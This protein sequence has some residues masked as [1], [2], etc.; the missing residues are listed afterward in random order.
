MNLRYAGRAALASGILAA[1]ALGS[2]GIGNLSLLSDTGN[3]TLG[4]PIRLALSGPGGAIYSLSMGLPGGAILPGVGPVD[5]DLAFFAVVANGP[6][7]SNGDLTF[8]YFVPLQPL[9]VGQEFVFQAAAVDPSSPSG[10]GVSNP[11]RVEIAPVATA[12]FAE[13]PDLLAWVPF[14]NGM[15]PA[16]GDVDGDGDLDVYLPTLGASLMDASAQ[17]VLLLNGGSGVFEDATS[18][19]LPSLLE[20]SYCA[21]LADLDG[22]F[23]LDVAVGNGIDSF[24]SQQPTPSRYYLND[25]TGHFSLAGLLPGGPDLVSSIAAGDVDGDGDVDLVLGR[26]GNGL[27][28]PERLLVND[29]TG[30]F[31]DGT[32]GPGTSL[33][34][35]TDATTRVVL[36]DVDKDGDPDIV[37]ANW[38]ASG[39]RVYKNAGAGSFTLLS[40]AFS[41]AAS[42]WWT[43]MALADLNGDGDLDAAGI[44]RL[45]GTG[46]DRYVRVF[47]NNGAGSFSY[48]T[49]GVT[50][51][52]VTEDLIDVALGDF[53]GDGDADVVAATLST[54]TDWLLQNDGTGHFAPSPGGI[55]APAYTRHPVPFDADGDNLLDLIYSANAPNGAVRLLVR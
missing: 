34:A 26:N 14:F 41:S 24:L 47:S 40:G 52:P 44:T 46:A 12:P 4:A 53:D 16:V 50:G 9:L 42:T 28:A 49:N 11:V 51:V 27:G 23:D 54:G 6:L 38:D 21:V 8:L 13:N 30:M 31:A 29:G 45:P 10:V 2:D 15:G 19:N 36:A 17:N 7:P 35:V 22:D 43:D 3:P 18:T 33:P 25:G 37:S 39:A 5:V 55:A 48:V 20:P 32:S 1:G